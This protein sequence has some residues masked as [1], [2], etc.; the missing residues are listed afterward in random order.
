MDKDFKEP[1]YK[2][3]LLLNL[4][5][6]KR[7]L[8]VYLTFAILITLILAYSFHRYFNPGVFSY[9]EILEDIT[10]ALFAAGICLF[11]IIKI[12]AKPLTE[13]AEEERELVVSFVEQSKD[14][15]MRR[16]KLTEFFN[17]QKKLD[18]L[19]VAHLE[20]IINETVSAADIIVSQ[21][22]DID[23]STLNLTN[24]LDSLRQQ[25]DELAKV[26]Q[27]TISENHQTLINLHD[28]VDKRMEEL[29]NDQ[30]KASAL[31]ENANSM[32][33][34]VD[35]IKEISDQT[36]LLALNAAIEAAR[37]GEE[38]K[39]FAVVADKVR[40]L[41]TQS[42]QAANQ[43]GKAITGMAKQIEAQFSDK[44]ISQTNENEKE[45]LTALESQLTRLGNGYEKLDEFK[46]I[47]LNQVDRNSRQV[48]QKVMEL[49]TNIQFQDITR[50]QIERVIRCL[51]DLDKYI[52]NIEAWTVKGEK[53]PANNLEFSLKHIENHYVAG[54]QG[55][56]YHEATNNSLNQEGLRTFEK[57]AT[58]KEDNI[59]FF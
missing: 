7:L 22:Q 27:S 32:I 48:A 34:L 21:A 57:E 51:S 3:T 17:Y 11:I 18:K 1:L 55:D 14:R 45:L 13:I 5:A 39:S 54:K 36:N 12:A 28:Y 20:N 59:T 58:S 33:K 43:V 52:E 6:L 23:Q 4:P 31:S 15:K 37:A 10:W 2:G 56:I 35:L 38:G 53:R 8:P 46:Q 49:L 25:S 29:E 42:E 40:E 16:A 26:S 50:Q 30:K 44:L 24:T 9:G 19:T 47:I 41:S